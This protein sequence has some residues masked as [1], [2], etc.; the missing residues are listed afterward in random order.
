MQRDGGQC[1]KKQNTELLI[2]EYLLFV[3]YFTD[4]SPK[5]TLLLETLKSGQYDS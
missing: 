1:L 5:V 2:N 3:Q 4:L